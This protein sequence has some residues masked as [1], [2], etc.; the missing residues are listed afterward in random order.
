MVPGAS[1]NTRQRAQ[2]LDRLNQ[3]NEFLTAQQLHATLRQHGANV[4]LTTIYRTLQMLVDAGEVDTM[5]LPSG[6][7]LYRRCERLQHHHHLACRECG[8]TIEIVVPV[9]ER[10]AES[11]AAQHGFTDVSHTLEIFGVC[12]RCASARAAG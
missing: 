1:R 3:E 2:I 6:E 8:T 9:V 4:G 7:T 5:R 12:R 11:L 10:F